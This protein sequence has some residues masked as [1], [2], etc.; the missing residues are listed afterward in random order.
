MAP[1]GDAVAGLGEAAEGPA[2]S[3][4]AG[5]SIF[6]GDLD[7]LEEEFRGYRGPQRELALDVAGLEAGAVGFH[8]E[9]TYHAFRV[10]GPDDRELGEGAVRDP[11]LGAREHPAVSLGLAARDHAR[12][13]TAEVGLGEPEATDTAS[14]CHV[15]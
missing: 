3:L 2:Q 5:Q 9:A 4:D 7:V 8:H 1:P 15:G 10:L 14:G 11:A 13:E 6:V 12:D